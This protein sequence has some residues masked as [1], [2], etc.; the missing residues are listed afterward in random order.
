MSLK[1]YYPLADSG[2]FTNPWPAILG[3]E[4]IM[5]AVDHVHVL[6]ELL[7]SHAMVPEPLCWT[8]SIWGYP[9]IWK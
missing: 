7:L 4:Q 6:L 5:D 3:R 2:I 8:P 1:Q 9:G